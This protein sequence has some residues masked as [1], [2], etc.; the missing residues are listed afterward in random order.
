MRAPPFVRRK[1]LLV[2]V[3]SLVA[4]FAV[5][6]GSDTSSQPT[7]TPS[8]ATPTPTSVPAT[9][10]SVPATETPVPATPTPS[11]DI[12][13]TIGQP[14][15]LLL[16]GSAFLDANGYRITFVRIVSDNRCPLNV[17]CI[18]GG[19]AVVELAVRVSTT[20]PETAYMWGIGPDSRESSTQTVGP[21]TIEL[22][23]VEPVPGRAAGLT[24]VVL[25]V[26]NA[27]V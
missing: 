10:T 19:A 4:L 21:F 27:G 16:G 20:T 13:P 18:T 15:E 9:P 24:Q 7:A 14:S 5:A 23:E 22:L 17:T 11:V 3:A 6:C 12:H 8:P 1:T 26:T 2:V 25:V